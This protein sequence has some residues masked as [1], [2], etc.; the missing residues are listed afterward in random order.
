MTSPLH[1]TRF[2]ELTARFVEG[3]LDP[4]ATAEYLQL[5]R[6]DAAALAYYCRYVDLHA[7]LE[8]EVAECA[9]PHALPSDPA[10]GVRDGAAQPLSEGGRTSGGASRRSIVRRATFGIAAALIVSLGVTMSLMVRHESQARRTSLN[11]APVATLVDTHHAVFDDASPPATGSQLRGGFLHLKS[12]SVTIEF[13]SGARVFLTGPAE[14]GLNSENHGFLRSGKLLAYCPPSAH[15]FTVGAPGCAVVDLGTRFALRVADGVNEVQVITGRVRLETPAHG[16]AAGQEQ[17]LTRH[18]AARVLSGDSNIQPIAFDTTLPGAREP[19]PVVASLPDPIHHWTF[20]ETAGLF[21]D[22]CAGADLKIDPRVQVGLPGPVGHAANL[23][24]APLTSV[25]PLISS[26]DSFTITAW[27]KP[28]DD[29]DNRE[30]QIFAAGF[31]GQR[32]IGLSLLDGKLGHHVA[33][34]YTGEGL[35]PTQ[36]SAVLSAD[37]ACP[38]GQWVHIA[39]VSP[40]LTDGGPMKLYINGVL[41]PLRP[42]FNLAGRPTSPGWPATALAHVGHLDGQRTSNLG[43]D[44]LRLYRGELSATQINQIMRDRTHP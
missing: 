18:H 19:E 1:E 14:F 35:K 30:C 41:Q 4:H 12:G 29:T 16:G 9:P 25:K 26:G 15:G 36:R 33:V 31:N 6:T 40:G 42:V 8:F 3:M 27:V 21:R 32:F 17:L 43:L 28:G 34:L 7:C 11:T 38:A 13:F 20:D 5:L 24:G 23:H 44:D 22:R 2:A 10:T 37:G 39:A